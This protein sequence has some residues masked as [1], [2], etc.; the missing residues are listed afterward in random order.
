[1][2]DEQPGSGIAI[3]QFYLRTR[4][5]PRNGEIT[6]CEYQFISSDEACIGGY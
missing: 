1:M 4:N 2:G 3:E 6:I 5:S